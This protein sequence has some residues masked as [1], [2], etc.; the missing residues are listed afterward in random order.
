MVQPMHEHTAGTTHRLQT[1][2]PRLSQPMNEQAT[3][4]SL[5]KFQPAT[6]TAMVL[7]RGAYR[8]REASGSLRMLLAQRKP[9]AAQQLD[10]P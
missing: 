8:L 5:L 7:I 4:N 1:F 9:T 2:G 6:V 3:W 10:G